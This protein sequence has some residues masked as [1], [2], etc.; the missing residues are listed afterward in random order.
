MSYKHEVTE[1]R[2]GKRFIQS[3]VLLSQYKPGQHIT[4]YLSQ[5]T[6]AAGMKVDA[7]RSLF[8]AIRKNIQL[9]LTYPAPDDA[10]NPDLALVD[11]WG[12]ALD[13][14]VKVVAMDR[15]EVASVA[16]LAD[17]LQKEEMG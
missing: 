10:S 3:S 7:S 14:I 1:H 16:P 8:E 13:A 12:Q 5:V 17:T 2:V 15:D 4:A 11:S 9:V 6:S